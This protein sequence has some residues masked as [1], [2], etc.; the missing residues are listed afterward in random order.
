MVFK[1]P[2][3]GRKNEQVDEM[4]NL[5]ELETDTNCFCISKETIF[6]K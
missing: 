1:I 4:T 5:D 3:Q 2:C 6:L